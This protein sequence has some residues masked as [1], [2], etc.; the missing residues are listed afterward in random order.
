MGSWYSA[1]WSRS[2]FFEN[3]PTEVFG[4]SSM[5]TTS[6]GNHHLATRGSRKAMTSSF[7]SA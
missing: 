2:V 4:T 1:N 7:V 6:S 3:L 5:N